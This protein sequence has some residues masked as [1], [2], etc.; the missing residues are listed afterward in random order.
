MAAR[1]MQKAILSLVDD[2]LKTFAADANAP[3]ETHRPHS[4]RAT[5]I[6]ERAFAHAPNITQAEKYK[7]AQATGLQPRQV[8]IWVRP[9]IVQMHAYTR[10]DRT[11]MY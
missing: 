7:L 4:V 10:L 3:H 1:D 5:A 9:R 6:L 11:C 8:T 2:R